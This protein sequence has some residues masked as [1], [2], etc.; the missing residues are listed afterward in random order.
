MTLNQ[1]FELVYYSHITLVVLAMI[2]T[3]SI[4][5][6]VHQQIEWHVILLVGLST[7]FTYSLDNLI[8]WKKDVLRYRNI[9]T[10]IKKYHKITYFFIPATAVGIIYLTMRSPNELKTA[11]LLLGAAVAMG[12]TRF[13]FYRNNS[14][15]PS[16]SIITFFINRLFISI[17]WTTVCVFLP[18]WYNNNEI[19]SQ[20][21]N[22]FFYIFCLVF[23]YAVLWKFESSFEELRHRLIGSRVFQILITLPIIAMVLVIRDVLRGM[24][25]MINL[26]NLLPPI[27][28]IAGLA[29]I[30]KN[31]TAVKKKVFVLTLVLTLLCG[32][33]VILHLIYK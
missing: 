29:M 13:S 31:H 12:T 16:Q 8:D 4:S 28:M 2:L 26:V 17:T 5:T 30:Q 14:T 3:G 20:T 10:I 21:W 18:I 33:S 7:Y 22:A 24:F 1:L 11:I 27:T 6:V 15:S 19:I 23:P 32:S 9:Q 25:P